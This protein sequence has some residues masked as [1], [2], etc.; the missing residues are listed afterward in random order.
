M[1]KENTDFNPYPQYSYN[2]GFRNDDGELV[3]GVDIDWLYWEL[4]HGRIPDLYMETK[5][6][7]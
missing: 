1:S 5:N 3:F 6:N 4:E 7:E 2:S